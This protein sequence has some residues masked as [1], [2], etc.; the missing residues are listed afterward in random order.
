MIK[1]FEQIITNTFCQ[2]HNE[3]LVESGKDKEKQKI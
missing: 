3:S 2:L 1:I